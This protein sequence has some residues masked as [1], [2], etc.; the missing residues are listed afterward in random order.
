MYIWYCIKYQYLS[1]LSSQQRRWAP[2]LSQSI[3]YAILRGDFVKI[4]LAYTEL[5]CQD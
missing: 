5:L 1:L 3:K 4:Y 2:N